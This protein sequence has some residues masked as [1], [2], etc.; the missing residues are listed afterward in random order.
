MT[1]LTKPD[2][3]ETTSIQ[4]T[5]EV[6]LDY[7][8][9]EDNEE[10][11]SHQKKLRKTIEEPIRTSDDVEF[12]QEEIKHVIESFNDKKSTWNRWYHRRYLPKNI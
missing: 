1:S 5:M 7:L 2:G 11:N 10:E 12:S 6:M 8:F 4:K 9:K 3:S